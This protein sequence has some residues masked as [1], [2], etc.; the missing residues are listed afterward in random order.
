MTKSL[1]EKQFDTA[2]M[3]IYTRAKSEAGYNASIF[4][5]LLVRQGGLFTAKQLINDRKE[6]TGY[7]ELFLRKR[8]DLTVEAVVYDNPKWHPLFDKDELHKINM[9]LKKYGY[10]EQ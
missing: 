7:T 8:L 10:F 1:L 5:Q 6:S 4:H 2:M 9:R 3:E